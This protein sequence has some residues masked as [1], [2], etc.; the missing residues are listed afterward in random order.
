MTRGLFDIQGK[1]ALVTGRSR[2]SGCMTARGPLTAGA[3]VAI[4]SHKSADI[5]T[6]ADE[7][8]THGDCV[9]VTAD[10]S[11]RRER[12]PRP[13]RSPPG[14]TGWTFWSTTRTTWNAPRVRRGCRM[15]L[16]D[17]GM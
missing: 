6:A 14:S 3:R 5:T 15:P 10:L 17:S 4:A 13:R 9:A 2:G 11:T 12:T 8:A 1:T 7:L 16:Q